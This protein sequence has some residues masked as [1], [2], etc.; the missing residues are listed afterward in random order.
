MQATVA[1][2]KPNQ[3]T[4]LRICGVRSVCEYCQQFKDSPATLRP[5][6]RELVDGVV[7]VA[8]QFSSEILNLCLESLAIILEVKFLRI[9]PV[10]GFIA[11]DHLLRITW[12]VRRPMH[13]MIL[14]LMELDFIFTVDLNKLTRLDWQSITGWPSVHGCSRGRRL[15][16]RHLHFP[17][18]Q[19][20][21]ALFL[22]FSSG[23][24]KSA[25]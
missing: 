17:E 2:I 14:F 23:G 11:A 24:P 22:C 15:Q 6:I 21:W 20:R 8:T 12:S 13:E 18:A 10:I 1:S 19:L 9:S 3:D 7:A 16:P 5:F 25:A 4:C